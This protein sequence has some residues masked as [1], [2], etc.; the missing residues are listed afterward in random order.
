MKKMNEEEL[1]KVWDEYLSTREIAPN[2]KLQKKL[3]NHYYPLIE[4]IARRLHQRITEVQIDEMISMGVDGLYYAIAHYD[5]SFKTK[6][7]TYANPRIKG[8][9]LDEIRDQDW[10]P[11]LV[12]TK[13]NW[14]DKQRQIYESQ[15]GKRLSNN[16][17]ADKI[18]KTKE[19]FNE[20]VRAC[21]APGHYSLNIHERDEDGYSGNS[22][23]ALEDVSIVQPLDDVIRDELFAKL[24]GKN[25]TPQERKIIWL[26]YY[27]D[28]SMKEISEKV[29][30]S[31]SRVSQMHGKILKRLKQKVERNPKYFSDIWD[32]MENFSKYSV[33]CV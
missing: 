13:T 15:S 3:V 7:E 30:L 6:F 11:R 29:Q 1:S 26:Y 23:E 27:E 10:V 20:M 14:L 5:R 8:S 2:A 18:G 33:E 32:E 16:E 12:R 31:E 4:N 25:F 9:I 22:M 17:L 24:L 28:N 21:E 19:E